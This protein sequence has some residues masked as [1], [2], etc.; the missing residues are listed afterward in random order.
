MAPPPAA[1]AA[2]RKTPSKLQRYLK[3]ECLEPHFGYL[4][5]LASYFLGR[6]ST[7]H[8]YCVIC[9]ETHLFGHG[10]MLKPAVCTREL[11]CFSFQQYGVGSAGTKEIATA[12]GVVDLLLCMIQVAVKSS[13]AKDIVKPFP[14]IF[15]HER[16]DTLILDPEKPDFE[17]LKRI[18]NCFPKMDVLC[19][20]SEGPGHMKAV[21]D[22]A[23]PYAFA[24]LSW[25][26]SSSR[27]H[28][29]KL[30]DSQHIREMKTRH[31]F[32][33]A[34]A[35]PE[36][37]QLFQ[38]LKAEHGSFFAFHGSPIAN[39]HSI[40]R[41][42]LRN[43]SGTK[44]QLHG[45]AHGAGI[46]LANNVCP[47]AHATLET[48]VVDGSLELCKKSIASSPHAYDNLLVVL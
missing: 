2:P 18:L 48:L 15:H 11:C 38:E 29:V 10:S 13:R 17:E 23:H 32:L 24:L 43:A 36:K 4:T 34:S 21:L 20:T 33:L 42:G 28:I 1:G 40:M 26:I 37:E 22:A 45:A 7:L 5:M 14:M 25:V 44:L 3:D 47:S 12:T 31:Q 9:D 6:M 46:Y 35:S 41:T 39:W 8:H 30:Q 19:S 27:C 16:Q